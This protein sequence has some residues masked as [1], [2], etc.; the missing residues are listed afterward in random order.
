MG[1]FSIFDFRWLGRVVLAL[2]GGVA[3]EG[4]LVEDPGGLGLL[5][6]V[7]KGNGERVYSA[8]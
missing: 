5:L 2:E 6:K 3:G 8:G 4:R 7:V 1:G